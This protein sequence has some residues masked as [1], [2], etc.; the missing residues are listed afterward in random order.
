ME[1]IINEKNQY[2]TFELDEVYGFPVVRVIEVLEVCKITRV[3]GSPAF[4]DGV[5]N[6]RGSVI[7]VIDLKKKLSIGSVGKSIDTR[8]IILEVCFDGECTQI[9]LLVDKVLEVFTFLP[10]EIEEKPAMGMNLKMEF[11]HGIGKK[12]EQFII[13]LNIDTLLSLEELTLKASA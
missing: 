5:I 3:P 10:D 1:E 12:D 4:I 2:L 11:I 7:P 9:G 6:S 8:I 13:L